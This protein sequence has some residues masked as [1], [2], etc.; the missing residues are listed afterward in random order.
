MN[1]AGWWKSGRVCSTEKID[2]AHDDDVVDAGGDEVGGDRRSHLRRDARPR[3]DLVAREAQPDDV[4]GAHRGSHRGDHGAGE[5]QAI[6]SPLVASLVGQ[7]GQELAHEAVLAGVDLHAVAPGIDGSRG[8]G[9]EAVDDGGDVVGLHPL[10]DLARRHLRHA[11]RGPQRRLAVGRRTLPAGVVERGD[12]E[13]SMGPAGGGD[14]RPPG[15]GPG[16]QRRPL[17]GPVGLVDARPLEDDRAAPASGPTL[18]VGG[19]ASGEAAVVVTEVGDVRA[20]QDAVRCRARSELRV[21]RAIAWR[22]RVSRSATSPANRLVRSE[23]L[24]R[25][26]A[27]ETLR[28]QE[29]LGWVSGGGTSPAAG[30]GS[31]PSPGGGPCRRRHRR[32]AARRGR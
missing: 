14:R 3:G 16:R 20:E 25:G 13:R 4:L 6:G 30:G 28:R 10:G 29:T 17:V 27:A 31:G 18:V 21:V 8:G 26:R 7:P 22:R 12:D 19:V 32:A 11:R 5:V 24:L 2:P 1:P 9:D 15:G 23:C